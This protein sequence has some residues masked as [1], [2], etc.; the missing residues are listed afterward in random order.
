M[1]MQLKR[2]Q[3]GLSP[4]I[5][6]V[7]FAIVA[8]ALG[9]LVY[10]KEKEGSIEIANPPIDIGIEA[11]NLP[12]GGSESGQ[13]GSKTKVDIDV[14]FTSQAPF[15]EWD[16]PRQQDGCEEAS[17]IMAMHW[18]KGEAIKSK[19]AAKEEILTL[20]HYQEDNFGEYHDS[21]IS[22]TA[23]RL[24]K[25]YYKYE[26]YELKNV[27]GADDI[28]AELEK[29][30]III[31]P[32]NGQALGNPNFTQPGPERHMLVIKGYDSRTSQFITNEPGTRK[33]ENYKYKKDVLF[34]AIRDYPSGYHVPIEGVV[35][36]M[37]VI[38]K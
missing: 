29:G 1:S 35:K 31:I 14:P 18:V 30:Y 33:G 34:N 19:E 38:K 37:L 36:K 9:G 6:V 12:F 4:L 28:I 21:S 23:E 25:A 15:G 13:T 22:D 5:I 17:V 8:L 3:K 32:A 7:F 16:D 24:V 26:N 2:L 10:W 20:S 27:T 11:P